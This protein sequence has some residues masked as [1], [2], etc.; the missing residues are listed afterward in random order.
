VTPPGTG[1]PPVG[2]A[3]EPVEY[4]YYADLCGLCDGRG[5]SGD[6]YSC[7]VCGGTGSVTRSRP[8][9]KKR[10]PPRSEA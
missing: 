1:E 10:H 7:Y 5:G 3:P 2:P 9:R 4:V 6:G 8:V